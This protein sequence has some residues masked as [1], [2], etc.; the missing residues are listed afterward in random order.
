MTKPNLDL[1]LDL[2]PA[3]QNLYC[4][5]K[6]VGATGREF[7]GAALSTVNNLIVL[8]NYCLSARPTHTMEI[9][10]SFGGSCIAFAS[11]HRA[12][13]SGAGSHTA[14]DPF[15]KT[16][17]DNTGRIAISETSFD[18]LVRIFEDY[19]YSALPK[20]NDAGER[21]QAIYVDGSHLFEDVFIDMY[22]SLKLLSDGGVIFL[23]D[24][25]DS[26]V[27]KVVRFVRKNMRSQLKEIDLSP[28]RAGI[29]EDWLRATVRRATGR[30]QLTAFTR[31]GADQREWNAPF[32]NF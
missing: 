29:S 21:F 26:H 32:V 15:Q 22:Y 8:T 2:C 19:S 30:S 12:N 16:V 20:L 6:I 3:L 28:F 25:S 23:D 4:A 24:S 5:N 11:Y 13:N 10:L 18:E 1:L 9:G 14:I 7:D 27:A 31:V 17:W